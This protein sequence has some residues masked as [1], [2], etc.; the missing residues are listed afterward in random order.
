MAK[1][2]ETHNGDAG[3]DANGAQVVSTGGGQVIN[4]SVVVTG[5]NSTSHVIN[6]DN[7]GGLNMTF[8]RR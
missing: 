4:N 1:H 3:T 8:N 7:H 2:S 5:E 6:G